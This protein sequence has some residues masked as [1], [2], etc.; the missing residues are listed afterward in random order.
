GP[1]LL[2]GHGRR[3]E[4]GGREQGVVVEHLLEVRHEPDG[5]DRVAVEAAADEV[6]HAISS[7]SASPA[8]AY[9]RRRKPTAG[10]AGNL[11][12]PPNP[13]Q[14]PSCTARRRGIAA[15]RMSSDSGS[16]D[17]ISSEA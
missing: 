12:A 1:A 7:A 4:V 10:P 2:A 11:G 9:R 14:V 6:V 3:L 16:A 8:P 5:V 13:P 17:G 15:A